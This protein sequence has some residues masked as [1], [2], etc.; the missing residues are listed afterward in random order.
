M[1]RGGGPIYSST[2]FGRAACFGWQH[3]KQRS[4]RGCVDGGCG[5]FSSFGGGAGDE[6]EEEARTRGELF[7]LRG[8]D[9]ARTGL[10]GATQPREGGQ[11][12]G[13]SG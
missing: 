1:C 10:R 11:A 12:H 6:V 9:L 5:K 7:C 3:W 2:S 4:Q 13:S 8:E